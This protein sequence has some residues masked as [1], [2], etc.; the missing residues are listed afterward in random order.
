MKAFFSLFLLAWTAGGWLRA[1]APAGLTGPLK[2][3]TDGYLLIAGKLATDSMDGVP[4]AAAA[5]KIAVENAPA[6]TFSPAFAH[7]VGQ[8]AAATD[9]HS[10]RVALQPVNSELIATL[11]QDHI[12][13]G[14]LH[15]VFCPMVKAYW[16]QGD[17]KTVRNPYMGGEM[18]DC[19]A[20]Q[21]QF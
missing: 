17:G 19:G 21:R 14:Q 12:Q 1:E 8:L 5:T 4:A 3:V 7:A 18:S 15:S 10:A 13:T 2:T 6:G 11:A 16:L 20:F 9:L